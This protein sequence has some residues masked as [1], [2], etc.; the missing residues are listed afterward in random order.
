[1]YDALRGRFTFSCP[2][3]GEAHVTLS[4]FRQLDRLP[5]S[6]HPVAYS[7]RFACS[8][9]DEHAGLVTHDDLDWAPLGL[10][11]GA[12]LNLMTSRVEAAGLELGELAARRI[13]A[14]E[15]PWSFFC[16]PEGRARPV[17]PSAFWLLTAAPRGSVALA[18]RCPACSRASV[19]VVSVPHVDVPFHN[20]AEVGVL[21]CVL[22]V[23]G[24]DIVSEF[25]AELDSS[26]FDTRRLS[27]GR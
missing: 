21:E 10:S 15:W 6:A 24:E 16:Y 27:L 26:R 3:R 13:G 8:C 2:S 14:G 4:A 9:G 11:A 17:F 5:G 12:F 22:R 1:M 25:R 23:D 18:V 19:N 7:V 20:D